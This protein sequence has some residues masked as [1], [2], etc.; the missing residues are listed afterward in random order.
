MSGIQND[1]MS[2]RNKAR[3]ARESTFVLQAADGTTRST[4][5]LA[6]KEALLARRD[7]VFTANNID[8]ER[9]EAEGVAVP[10]VK[11]LKFDEKKLNTV[12]AGLD[13]LRGL[14][15]P[16]GRVLER[17]ELDDG[18]ILSRVSTPLGV[19]GM[20]FESRP[21]AL[22]QIASLAIKS[23]NALILK[24]GS[25]A[26]ESNRVLAAIIADA[27]RTAGL[28]DGWV[29][30]IE[31]RE[32][33]RALLEQDEYVD[34]LV[35][36][37]SNEFVRF[38]MDNSRIPVLGHADGICHVYLD[39]T[40]EADVAGP[41]VMD[42]KTQYVAVCNAAETLLVHA[43]A[44]P[45]LL[46]EIGAALAE[47]GV[48]LRACPRARGFLPDASEAGETDWESEYLDMI[49]AV[50]VVDSM[51]E[52]ITHINR[53]GSHHTDAIITADEAAAE[54]FLRRV[55]SASVM[56]NASTRFAD[57][58]RYG[59][60]SEI[61]ISTARIHARGPVGIEGMM[62]YKWLLRGNGQI[63]ADYAEG[64]RSFTHRE[65]DA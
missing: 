14:P 32:D 59:L 40:A 10:L 52:A 8:L 65:L 56:W 49:L 23:G 55:D 17:R 21:D 47:A 19:V 57:G 42:S 15:D 46:P 29:H 4:V 38:I 44:A 63:V 22:V 18:L 3:R 53:Y 2:V 33:V 6:V 41:L 45:R 11:R 58:Y 1:T 9:A 26:R 39:A 51:D 13:A 62:S 35:P 27:S 54:S 16:V 30:L 48:E 7:E 64:R 37:G 28:P 50:K 12:V 25:E 36:R 20:I 34:L 60:G 43:E 31:S 5:L 61:G 24:G